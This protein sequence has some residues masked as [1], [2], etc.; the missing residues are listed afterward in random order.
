MGKS[1]SGKVDHHSMASLRPLSIHSR[2]PLFLSSL[3]FLF[4]LLL[5]ACDT[6]LLSNRPAE[7]SYQ[8]IAS[9]PEGTASRSFLVFGDWGG[10]KWWQPG[11][12]DRQRLVAS[13]MKKIKDTSRRGADFA[14]AVGDNFYANGVKS[15]QDRKWRSHFED[16]YTAEQFPMPFYM[17][18]GNHDYREDPHAQIA[19]HQLVNEHA[20]GRWYMP[21]WYYT[22]SDTLADSTIVQF[23]NLDSQMLINDDDYLS[24]RYRTNAPAGASQRQMAWLEDELKASRARWKFV[25]MHHPIFSNGRHGNT[26]WL[27]EHLHPLLERYGVQAVFSGHNH[28][29]E[30]IKPIEGVHYFVSGAAANVNDVAWRKNT[31]YAHAGPGFLWCRITHDTMAAVFYNN[32]AKERWAITIPHGN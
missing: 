4:T 8:P 10:G 13:G 18:L 14:V 28:N 31:L 7:I 1:A 25:V 19:Y 2:W 11:S 32:R 30:A 21:D 12:D 23:F 6:A 27:I 16:V 24:Y 17:V 22:F 26:P 20:T 15:I 5:V 3:L 9:L 29:L